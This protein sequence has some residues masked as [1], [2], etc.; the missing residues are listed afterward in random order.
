MNRSLK[1]FLKSAAAV[2][3]LAASTVQAQTNFYWNGGSPLASPAGGGTGNWDTA[4]AWRTVTDTGN[5][6]TWAAG[7]GGTNVGFLA[8]TS[9]TVTLGSTGSTNFTGTSLTVETTGYTVTST[10]GS[11]NLVM[12]GGPDAR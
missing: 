2:A 9:G 5:Q 6:G 3:V 12:T 7:T 1:S 11:C 4:N 10:S 8:G